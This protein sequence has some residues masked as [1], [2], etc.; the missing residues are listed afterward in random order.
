MQVSTDMVTLEI[1]S[2]KYPASVLDSLPHYVGK[3]VCYLISS[4]MNRQ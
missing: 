1:E 2:G 3:D 4:K